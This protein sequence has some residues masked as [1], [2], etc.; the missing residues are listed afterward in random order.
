[1]HSQGYVVLCYLFDLLQAD[2]TTPLIVL[3]EIRV[4]LSCSMKQ[5]I[6]NA[7]VVEA[8]DVDVLAGVPFHIANNISFIHGFEILYY[9]S[10][11]KHNLDTRTVQAATSVV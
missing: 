4:S 7:L 11:D 8:L 3:G 2:G 6:L 5:L 1:M 9:L 10:K